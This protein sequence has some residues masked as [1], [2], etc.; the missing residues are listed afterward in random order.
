MRPVRH[1]QAGGGGERR[2]EY[3]A[4]VRDL[5]TSLL[6]ALRHEDSDEARHLPY[7]WNGQSMR[8]IADMSELERDS[9]ALLSYCAVHRGEYQTQ[10]LIGE[11]I[12]C[13]QQRV[14]Y[15]LDS[16]NINGN[17]D[18]GPNEACLNITAAK[19]GFLFQIQHGRGKV[20]DVVRRGRTYNNY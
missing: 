3:A 6:S 7:L 19:Y 10:T 17:H 8:K 5:Q 1:Q 9:L 14:C 20:I 13:S 12:G 16:V 4:Y 2:Y 11:A 18:W 15:I